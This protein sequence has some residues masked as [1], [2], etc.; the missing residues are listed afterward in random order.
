MAKWLSSCV[1]EQPKIREALSD[2][3]VN[4]REY[5][6]AAKP[7]AYRE[8]GGGFWSPKLTL[9]R[10][11][12]PLFAIVSILYGIL[13]VISSQL[14]PNYRAGEWANLALTV[15][16]PVFVIGISLVTFAR[17]ISES[18]TFAGEYLNDSCRTPWFCCLTLVTVLC[19]LI[20][21]F[22]STLEWFPNVV[23]VGL[24]AASVGAAINCLAM[25]AFVILETMRCSVP[26]ESIRVASRYAARKLTYGYVNDSYVTLFQNQ[27]KDYLEKWCA[28]KTIHPPSQYYGHYLR[29]SINSGKGDNDVEIEL[30]GHKWERYVYKDYDLQGLEK[31]E[32]YLKE[33]I[34]KLYLSSPFYEGERKVLGILS[35]ANAKQNERLQSK[36]YKMGGN[37]IR[38]QK[39]KFSEKDEDFWDSQE[40]KLNEAIKRAVDKADPIQI[41]A[42]LDSVNVPLSVLRKVRR[43]HKVIRDAYGEHVER[44][45]QFLKLYLKALHEI[46]VMKESDYIFMLARVVRN[47]VWEETKNILRDMDYHTME[48]YTWLVRQMYALIQ[49]EEEKGKKLREM[50]GQFGGFYEFASGWLEDS[51]SKNAEDVNKMRLVLHEGLT[52]WLLTAIRKKDFELIEQLCDAGRRIVFGREEINFDNKEVI[53]RHFVLAGYLIGLAKSKE[54]N[55]TTIERLFYDRYSLETKV[56]LD[57]LVKFYLDTSLPFKAL[58]SFLN[59]FYSPTQVHKDLLTGS[60]HSSGYGMTGV[61][62]MSLAFIFLAAHAIMNCSQPPEPIADMSGRITKENIDIIKEVF[63]DS[64]LNHGLGKLEEWLQKCAELRDEE[65]AKEIAEAKIDGAKVKEHK[66]KFW[67]GYSRTVPVLSMCLKNG[68]YEI[69][70]EVKSE[71][72]YIVPK[73]ALYDYKYPIS[74]ADGNE[75]GFDIGRKMENNILKVI[76]EGG[77]VES[78]VKGGL[79]EAVGEAVK[80]LEKEG[81]SN[82]KENINK[83]GIVI[84]ES[85]E[86][87]EIALLKDKDF[88]PS[89]REDVKSMGFNGFYR[90]FPIVCLREDKEEEKEEGKKPKCQKVVAVDLRGWIGLRVRKEVVAER[91]FGELKIRTWTDDEINQAIKTGKL[92]AKDVYKAKGNCP[93]DVTFYWE[94]G[95]DKLP[96]TRAFKLED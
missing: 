37:A 13:G 1:K 9:F 53:A 7:S 5:E 6:D 17:S 3:A 30:D 90:G 29:S 66:R 48:L 64:L 85:K 55:A 86:L 61:Q 27:Q 77:N 34:A 49:D 82:D 10:P 19:G 71:W 94:F 44:G 18:I 26:N 38:R 2:L 96:K 57:E 78:E 92:D 39:S 32:K 52:K 70:N 8:T 28:G 35:C 25:L 40:S 74:G 84:V 36:V 67:V 68:N 24:C 43:K 23:T 46:F 93:V 14:V 62:E 58:D 22:L 60:S 76:V 79:S 4:I 75:Y 83:R 59:I 47:S 41:K 65:E 50:R 73:I 87:P 45:Y 91:K 33:N 95:G 81:C 21:R 63:K 12:W 80:W 15:S 89:W 20:G 31:L 51:K 72:R 54:V 16:I 42:Y 11:G 56:N 69:D 88:V